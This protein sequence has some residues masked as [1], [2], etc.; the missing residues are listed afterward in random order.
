MRVGRAWDG[1]RQR[2][3]EKGTETLD[4]STEICQNNMSAMKLRLRAGAFTGG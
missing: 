2:S 4:R 3:R 1:G